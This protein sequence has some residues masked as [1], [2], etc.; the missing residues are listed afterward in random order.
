MYFADNVWWAV[1]IRIQIESTKKKKTAKKCAP[2]EP[3][4]TGQTKGHL[5]KWPLR[6]SL[7]HQTLLNA[8]TATSAQLDRS[9][10]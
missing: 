8:V 5:Q 10:D 9:D 4:R 2:L 3:L 7:L 1:P 6:P